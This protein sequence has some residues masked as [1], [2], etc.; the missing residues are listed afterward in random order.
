M[1]RGP[2]I[3][4]TVAPIVTFT[5]IAIAIWLDPTFSVTHDALSDLGVRSRSRYAFNG[6]MI[7]GGALGVVYA[8][9]LYRESTRFPE[10]IVG[11]SFGLAC[12]ALA[13]IGIFVIGHP[14]HSPAAVAFFTLFGAAMLIDGIERRETTTGLVTL[15]L[16]GLLILNFIA[17]GIGLWPGPGLA[18]PELAGAALVPLWVWIVGPQPTLR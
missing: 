10:R 14:L 15:V 17:W 8:S 7:L 4:G 12:A 6:A 1:E 16:L 18:L 3:A 13:G 11:V 9:G 5:G 2:W